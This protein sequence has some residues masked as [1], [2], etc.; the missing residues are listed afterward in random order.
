MPAPADSSSELV[1]LRNTET[2]RVFDQHDGCIRNI[3]PNFD[4]R[5]RHENIDLAGRERSHDRFLL[6]TLQAS[7][8]QR[9]PPSGE[10]LGKLL[11]TVRSGAQI[12]LFRLF[13]QRIN[14]VTLPSLL[15][16]GSDRSV[17][18]IR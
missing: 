14:N 3:D 18:A 16:L 2:F 10:D 5:R 15:Q 17:N 7:V 12:D 4:D 6:V 9:Q 13:D 8:Q 11:E 1:K